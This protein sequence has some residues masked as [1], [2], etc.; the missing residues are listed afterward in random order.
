MC[1]A[2]VFPRPNILSFNVH[3][4]AIQG[5]D[6]AA[7]KRRKT[8]ANFL[9]FKSRSVDIFLVQEVFFFLR[10]SIIYYRH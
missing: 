3:G 1:S 4:L 9:K 10:D 5:N 2:T 6:D 7:K 8:I